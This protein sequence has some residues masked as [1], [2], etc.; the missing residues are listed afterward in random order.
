MASK[1][2]R[3]NSERGFG[4]IRTN[5]Q[6]AFLH[7]TA[8]EPHQ[9]RGVD[10]NGREVE[11]H[12]VSQG[13]KGPKVTSATLVPTAEEQAAVKAEA[14]RLA[15]ERADREAAKAVEETLRRELGPA[16]ILVPQSPAWCYKG[17]VRVDDNEVNEGVMHGDFVKFDLPSRGR[18]RSVAE[19]MFKLTPGQVYVLMHIS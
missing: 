5:G 8:I 7:V 14:A 6:D 12:Q 19:G 4:F 15:Q 10:L 17:D 3:W 1:I 18:M 9:Y 16:T 11:V 13:D 2:I